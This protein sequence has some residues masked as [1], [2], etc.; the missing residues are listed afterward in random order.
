MFVGIW[1]DIEI[2]L[3]QWACIAA[4]VFLLEQ[5]LLSCEDRVAHVFCQGREAMCDTV[6]LSTV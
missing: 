4:A 2:R 3:V 6:F 5:V 1:H